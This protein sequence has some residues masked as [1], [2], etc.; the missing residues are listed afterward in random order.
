[1]LRHSAT[2]YCSNGVMVASINCIYGLNSGRYLKAAVVRGEETL[3]IRGQLR[4]LVN[5][6]DDR[7]RPRQFSMKDVLEIGPAYEDRLA[8]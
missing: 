6:H 1:M 2:R 5:N 3:N 4:E 7:N 8:D